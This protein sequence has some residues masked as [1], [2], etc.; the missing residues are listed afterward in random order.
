MITA[1][2]VGKGFGAASL[3][4]SSADSTEAVTGI[5]KASRAD[6]SILLTV[7]EWKSD[8]NPYR[9][10]TLIYDMRLTVFD[11]QAKNLAEKTTAG[12][13]DLGG[14]FWA[15]AAYA[16]K[17]APEAFKQKIEQLLNDPEFAKALH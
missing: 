3:A 5:I 11:R 9:D 4:V 6:R 1:A 12:R 8:L 16:R 7:N 13:D 14:D 10:V 2:L 15:P 17:K